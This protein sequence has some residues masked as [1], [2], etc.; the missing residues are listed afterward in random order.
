MAYRR[1]EEDQSW[2]QARQDIKNKTIRR[3]YVLYGDERYLQDQFAGLVEQELIH[4]AAATLDR[5]FIRLTGREQLDLKRLRAETESPPFLSQRRLVLIQGS[6]L[7]AS[8]GKGEQQDQFIEIITTLPDSCCVVFL[9]EKIDKRR[10]ALFRAIDQIGGLVVQTA[11]QDYAVLHRWIAAWCQQN[12]LRI[13]AS[14]SESLINRCEQKMTL[15]AQELQKIS[16]HQ[17]FIGEQDITLESVELLSRPDVR[18]TIFN[19]T[20][21]VT[22][23]DI[24]E[25]LMLLDRLIARKEPVTLIH[26]MLTRHVRQLLVARSSRQPCD[27]RGAA[28]DALRC[29]TLNGSARFFR[30]K[31]E[32]NLQLVFDLDARQTREDKGSSRV[33]NPAR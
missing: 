3:L 4:P 17:A 18:G 25:V 26:F 10:K 7:F 32:R 2:Q 29:K 24:G 21:A 28:R 13:T 22:A 14:A 5:V 9:E 23:G 20:D 12:N 1:G 16:L 11:L 33:G 30:S 19:L 31:T 8:S 15:L 27:S 6:G